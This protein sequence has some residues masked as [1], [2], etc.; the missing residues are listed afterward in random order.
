M[1]TKRKIER[2][3]GQPMRHQKPLLMTIGHYEIHKTTKHLLIKS[4]KIPNISE[5]VN[6]TT[7]NT[8]VKRKQT[9]GQTTIYKALHRKLKI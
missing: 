9:K 3:F 1:I 5:S 7:D 4:L 6:R 2:S 8:M